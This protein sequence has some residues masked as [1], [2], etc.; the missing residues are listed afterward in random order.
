MLAERTE[1]L[2]ALLGAQE[3]LSSWIGERQNTYA[4]QLLEAL[5]AQRQKVL[6]F[7]SGVKSWCENP[8]DD[9]YETSIKHQ[10]RFKRRLKIGFGGI[11]LALT[12]GT[13]TNFVLDY[14][15]IHWIFKI[16]AFVATLLGIGNPFASV[17]VIIGG[18]SVFTWLAA[19]TSHF[20]S[21]VKF[22]RQLEKQVAEA[23]YYLRAV[24]EIGSQK[25]KIA[26]LH[27]QVQDY[28]EFMAEVL[29]KPWVINEKWLDYE[30]T[31]IDSSKLP[32]SLVIAKPL[33]S[34][35][36]Q[37][38]TKKVIEEFTSTNWRSRQFEILV[39]EAE[40][41]YLV[42]ANTLEPRINS[43]SAIR[44]KMK[45]DLES[46]ELLDSVGSALVEDL[47][48][49]L[50]NKFLPN[51]LGFHVGSVKPDAL[52]SLDLSSSVFGSSEE[53]ANWHTFVTSILGQASGW[54]NL[55]FS[56]S[57]LESRL[58]GSDS[59][60]SFA[61]IPERLREDVL[62]PIEAVPLRKNENSGVEVVVRVDVTS[63]LDPEKV[64]LLINEP[65]SKTA[66][67]TASPELHRP[68]VVVRG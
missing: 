24:K 5:H 30:T 11:I 65:E 31:A 51:Q 14:F 47:A 40:K 66:I 35:I 60:K 29:Q 61:L 37:E 7:E 28:L 59:M 32:T 20:R 13:I 3:S 39:R 44:E 27:A 62:A 48:N 43:D 49:Q 33:E 46:T 10:K 18:L 23:R 64:N 55:A 50:R 12:I 68:D 34:G 42:G 54:S 67:T 22:R 15:H 21:Y 26:S 2:T 6:D 41:L 4:W 25:A 9:L 58:A 56:V 36:Y 1:E 63:W 45:T 52:G 57:G 38:V 19:L 17:P 16:L 53:D 8:V